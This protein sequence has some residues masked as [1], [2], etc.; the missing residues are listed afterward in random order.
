MRLNEQ[1]DAF[2]KDV[3]YASR[4]MRRSPGFSLT[5]ILTLALGIGA[6][7]AVF[8]VVNTALLRP[9]PYDHPE[10]VAMIW[11]HWQNWPQTW[12]SPSEAADYARQTDLFDGVSP[13]YLG[14]ATLTGNG[15]PERVRTGII[16]AGLLA[17]VGVRPI[18]GRDFTRA[19][20]QPNGPRVVM[21]DYSLWQRRF[22]G[23]RSIVG[24]QI[25]VSGVSRTVVAVL[26]KDFRLPLEFAGEWSQ[27]YMPIQLGPPT[28]S[29]RW[30]H[31][32]YA[33]ARLRSGTSVVAANARFTSFVERMKKDN[34]YY[35]PDFG[36]TLVSAN[37]QV[38]GNSRR[39]LTLLL[40]AVA[41]VLLIGCANVA[42]LLLSRGEARQR[43]IAIR[44]A[45]GAG[46]RRLARQLLTESLLLGLVGGVVAIP[47]AVLAGPVVVRLGAASLP[48]ADAASFDVSVLLFTFVISVATSV[49][50]GIAPVVHALRGDVHRSL[51]VSRGTGGAR[52]RGGATIR[53][54]IVAAQ[55]A[56]AVMS[57][58]GAT[59]MIKSFNTLLSVAPGFRP[60]NVLT[61]RLS[62]PPARYRGTTSI[63][64]FYDDFLNRI[65]AIPSVRTA[66]AVSALPLTGTLADWG[67]SI[68]GD[69]EAP[70]PDAHQQRAAF[71]WQM[72]TPGY[73]E[74]LGI[75]IRRGRAFSA[76]DTKAAQPVVIIGETTARKFWPNRDALGS[77]IRLGG[78]QDTVWRE[79]VGIAAD[80][81]H[82]ALDKEIRPEMYLPHSQ[83]PATAA[84]SL[85]L[86]QNAMSLVVRS[87]G[88]PTVMTSDIRNVLRSLDPLL[89]IAQVR[90]METVLTQ[91]VATP[92]LAT[93]LLAIFG[94]LALVL[95]AIGVY[96]VM[97]YSVAQ[98]TN[99][100]GIRMALGAQ[101]GDVSRLIVRQGM[102]PAVL[103]IAVGIAAALAGSR[104][105][106]GLL[107]GV[108][109]T[110]KASLVIAVFVLGSV[111][112]LAT[113]LPARRVSRVDPVSSLRAD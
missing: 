9:L 37:D 25:D 23:D 49:V 27:L 96:G 3:A 22:A 75:D 34:H 86:G 77:R 82:Q 29:D 107:F 60:D 44:A 42:N 71:D 6:N 111:A 57:V 24:K 106:Q 14:A 47:L 61:M 72:A 54:I 89:P 109:P 28:K 62:L 4:A 79:V 11:S 40:G 43:E 91:S 94:T 69:A 18:M 30:G 33:V 87:Q 70:T 97:S 65:R 102:L 81:H 76:G 32:L 95:S 41:F 108:S 92:R 103:G 20:D 38:F 83:F 74:A 16:A 5:A 110:D 80:V 15:E 101:A 104:L 52:G 84:D 58:A 59:V 78:T 7:A 13:F 2:R 88:D 63:R 113:M 90:T 48:R 50:F 26:P 51:R 17:T 35:D 100:I 19:E 68:A 99:E 112:F 67:V 105:M 45:L 66:G 85:L 8:G 1:L 31:Y 21:L 39:V 98:R 36:A 93:F 10:R 64:A 73:F 46:R 53:Q 56:L 12:V 55:V